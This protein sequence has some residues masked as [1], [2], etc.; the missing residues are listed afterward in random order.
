MPLA[1]G[2][3]VPST[4]MTSSSPALNYGQRFGEVGQYYFMPVAH[5]DLPSTPAHFQG[6]VELLEKGSTGKL[7]TTPPATRD[8]SAPEPTT[9]DAHVGSG[10]PGGARGGA[11]GAKVV[12][13][14]GIATRGQRRSS[15]SLGRIGAWACR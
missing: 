8:S 7:S 14:D 12:G 15:N 5:G 4:W 9:Y 3:S 1:S 11:G 2:I 6:I 10:G 13:S